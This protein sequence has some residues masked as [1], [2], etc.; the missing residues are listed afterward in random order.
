M[1]KWL[2]LLTVMILLFPCITVYADGNVIINKITDPENDFSFPEDTKL[3]EIYVPK[4]YDCDAT[5]IRYGEYSMLLDCGG[6]L[7]EEVHNMLKRLEVKELTYAFLSHPHS[8]H[9]YGFQFV[10][11]DIRPGA[12]LYSY[13]EESIHNDLGSAPTYAALHALDLPFRRIYNGEDIEFGDIKMSVFQR[14]EEHLSG[15]NLS[16]MLKVEFGERSILFPA[17]IQM[18]SQRLYVADNAPIQADI[19]KAPH[20]GYNGIQ[21]TF[22]AAVDPELAIVTSLP[23]FA[24]CVS[25]LKNAKIP[26]LFTNLGI[27]KLTTDGQV[28]LVERIK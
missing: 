1:K 3:L 28:W 27:L 11:A 19:M 10:L 23:A 12:F 24:E 17:D 21:P 4:I 18:D 26:Y 22:L 9:M 6:A 16:S 20:H 5:F 7:W 13:P 15:N 14:T 2:L 8:D 25:G